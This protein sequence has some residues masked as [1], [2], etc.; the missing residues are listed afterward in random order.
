VT[1]WRHPVPEGQR[2]ARA[3]RAPGRL[4]GQGRPGDGHRPTAAAQLG[5]PRG[6]QAVGDRAGGRRGRGLAEVGPR[7]RSSGPASAAMATVTRA[8]SGRPNAAATSA[9]GRH[10]EQRSTQSA[11]SVLAGGADLT[12][13]SRCDG[14][15]AHLTEAPPTGREPPR[16]AA[17]P[18]GSLV[19]KLG[20][21][22][23]QVL[24]PAASTA[25]QAAAEPPRVHRCRSDW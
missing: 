4:P 24:V 6:R 19:N 22:C 3:G 14:Q 1:R 15:A 17:E 18:R 13:S 11:P 12:G 16:F 23:S 7:P 21:C 10:S 8:G 25:A 9:I 20:C 2:V 5:D